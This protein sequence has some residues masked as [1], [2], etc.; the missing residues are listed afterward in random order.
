MSQLACLPCSYSTSCSGQGGE[1]EPAGRSDS[2]Y[3]HTRP[4]KAPCLKQF[5]QKALLL[6]HAATCILRP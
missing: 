2:S 3:S 1:S 4:V 6:R 5:D